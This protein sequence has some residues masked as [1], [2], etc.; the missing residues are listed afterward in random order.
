VVTTV[1]IVAVMTI[2]QFIGF[3]SD[4]PITVPMLKLILP[5]NDENKEY[6]RYA[7]SFSK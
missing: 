1:E 6:V 2:L 7:F 5:W 4:A 3:L